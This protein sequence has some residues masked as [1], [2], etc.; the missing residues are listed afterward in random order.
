MYLYSKFLFYKSVRNQAYYNSFW[1]Y[2]LVKCLYIFAHRRIRDGTQALYQLSYLV[3]CTAQHMLR[4]VSPLEGETL[5]T[6][7]KPRNVYMFFCQHILAVSQ[8]TSLEIF[9]AT[10]RIVSGQKFWK[11]IFFQPYLEL[12]LAITRII[13]RSENAFFLSH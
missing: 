12:L 1:D 3:Y 6:S 13:S 11:A 8:K 7:E 4:V 5:S 2:L 10:S 9:L